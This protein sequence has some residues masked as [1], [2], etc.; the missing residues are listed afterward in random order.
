M[1]DFLPLFING[2]NAEGVA[3]WTTDLD[4]AKMF[5]TKDGQL[6][7]GNIAIIFGRA[8]TRDEIVLNIVELWNASGF[9]EAVKDYT[10]RGCA[11]ASA[12][13]YYRYEENQSEVVLDAPIK[14]S[15]TFSF[16][17]RVPAYNELIK[18]AGITTEAEE[19]EFDK[20][21]EENKLWPGSLFW[22]GQEESL[23]SVIR[24]FRTVTKILEKHLG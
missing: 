16:C 23:K 3:S 21:L 18:A 24:T 7:V 17:E 2:E 5:R 11:F 9:E 1:G 14:L 6:R 8:P 22:K 20:E 12:L 13:N 15:E 19:A 10:D 4:F